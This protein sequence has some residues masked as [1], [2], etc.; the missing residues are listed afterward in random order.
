MCFSL[1][2]ILVEKENIC[3]HKITAECGRNLSK[4]DCTSMCEQMLDCGHQCPL[5]CQEPCTTKACKRQ[6]EL[7]SITLACGHPLKGECNLRYA[8]IAF[9]LVHFPLVTNATF[10]FR[11]RCD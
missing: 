11:P 4:M 1:N 9:I 5:L 2:R 3:G 6:V 7:N 8:G 10:V